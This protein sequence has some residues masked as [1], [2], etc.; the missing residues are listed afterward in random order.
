MPSLPNWHSMNSLDRLLTLLSHGIPLLPW[1]LLAPVLPL[2]GTVAVPAGIA[3]SLLTRTL[4]KAPSPAILTTASLFLSIAALSRVTHAD[5]VTPLAVML[6]LLLG[7]RLLGEK[8]GRTTLQIAALS[9]LSLA[10]ASVWELG[11]RYLLVS[12]VTLTLSGATIVL[13]TMRQEFPP[14]GAMPTVRLLRAAL[15]IPAAALPVAFILFPIL[16]RTQH[17]LWNILP[18]AGG[19]R[20]GTAD[21]VEPGR[22]ETVQ[23]D[24]GV[25][26]RAETDPLPPERLYWRVTVF[27]TFD[28]VTWRRDPEPPAEDPRGGG[29]RTGQR[30]LT[31]FTPSA[32]LPTLDPPLSVSLPRVRKSPDLVFLPSGIRKPLLR[33]EAASSERLEGRPV[34]IRRFVPFYT[35]LPSIDRRFMEAA[36]E[37]SRDGA[38]STVR[39]RRIEELFQRRSLRYGTTQLAGGSDPAA[40]FFFDGGVGNCEH[41]ASSFAIIARASGIPARL[42]GGYLGG[43][44]NPILSYYLVRGSH[45]HVW[46]EVWLEG[47][48]WRRIDPTQYARPF[49]EERKKREESLSTRIAALADSIDYWWS[50][51]VLTYDLAR[52]IQTL[53]SI[54]RTL[55]PARLD[56]WRLA[57]PATILAPLVMIVVAWRRGAFRRQDRPRRLIRRLDRLMARRG[58]PP[59]EPSEGVREY[60]ER[61]GEPLLAEFA[62]L[63]GEGVY[64]EGSIDDRR[65]ALLLELVK[66]MESGGPGE[67]PPPP[68]GK[69][70][71]HHDSGCGGDRRQ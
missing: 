2:P 24:P 16:P 61:I 67:G 7:I 45:A 20:S 44:F 9:I 60:A 11:I 8:S 69:D 37:I 68:E 49:R 63:Y 18:A 40:A 12:L 14:E 30:I 57:L 25:A 64:R 59:R 55:S 26:F 31:P 3:G 23:D 52:Q 51:D 48:G 10:V 54:G 1:L 35:E 6:Q 46:V 15:F 32:P 50:Q 58:H 65:Y 34:D 70:P 39:L 19:S 13:V 42:V 17:P 56:P 21:R 4:G 38:G 47:E 22:S 28:G 33:Y 27:N 29:A 71:D 62:T 43:D 41:F 66:R 53:S 36:R 5:P